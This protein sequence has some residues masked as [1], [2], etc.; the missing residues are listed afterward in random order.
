[1]RRMER[2]IGRIERKRNKATGIFEG[3]MANALENYINDAKEENVLLFK[4][5]GIYVSS[6][7]TADRKN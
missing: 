2:K 7:G 3:R 6:L 5:P 1:M 4:E